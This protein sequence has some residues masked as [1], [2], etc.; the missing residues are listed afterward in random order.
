M[1]S[2]CT[3]KTNK[4]ESQ[5]KLWTLSNY[6]QIENR[7]SNS[8]TLND[9]EQIMEKLD[10]N[11]FHQVI[12]EKPNGDLMEVGGSLNEDGLCVMYIEEGKEFIISVPPTTVSEMTNFLKL[13]LEQDLTYKTKYK[14]E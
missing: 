9:I 2:S 1:I 8:A 4:N 7:I 14:F 13:Y 6:G 11:N 5:M 12:L 10:W 3:I